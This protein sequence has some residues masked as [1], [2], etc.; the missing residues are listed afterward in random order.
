MVATA[1][2][3]E[4]A[5]PGLVVVMA[6][7]SLKTTVAG[8]LIV[9]GAV[10]DATAGAV[11][12]TVHGTVV[13]ATSPALSDSD[14]LIV[15]RPSA[16]E[17]STTGAPMPQ[18][19]AGALSTEHWTSSDRSEGTTSIEADVMLVRSGG[20]KTSGRPARSCRRPSSW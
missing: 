9:V 5:I 20:P 8:P 16:R 17:G 18:A 13:V 1:A 10:T 14:A 11:M 3:V 7:S 19:V 2:P 6:A 4:S 15:W 12:S